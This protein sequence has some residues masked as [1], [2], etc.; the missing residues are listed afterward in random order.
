M[1][2]IC[3]NNTSSEEI[4]EPPDGSVPMS[5]HEEITANS[6]TPL[7]RSSQTTLIVFV[8]F[9]GMLQA[10]SSLVSSTDD[11]MESY[12]KQIATS[13]VCVSFSN[14]CAMDDHVRSSERLGRM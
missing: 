6:H 12:E 2:E 11:H 14:M 3:R 9:M 4:M 10:D 13:S 5:L 7:E 1:Y 8:S